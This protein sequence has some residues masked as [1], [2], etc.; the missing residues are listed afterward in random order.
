NGT[1]MSEEVKNKIFSAFFSTKGG[2]GTGL[3]L[4]VVQK[5]VQEQKGSIEIVSELGKGS[6]FIVR[7]PYKQV[8]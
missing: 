6:T 5:L 2:R 8:E 4:L 1:G 3:G 7:L